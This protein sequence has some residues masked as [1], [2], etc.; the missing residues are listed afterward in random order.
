MMLTVMLIAW[1]IE[2]CP[3]PYDSLPK[4]QR[5]RL[6]RETDRVL[7]NDPDLSEEDARSKAASL[8]PHLGWIC[9][10]AAVRGSPSAEGEPKRWVAS[11]LDEEPELLEEFWADI[12]QIR[13]HG[14]KRHGSIRWV[15]FNGKRFDVPFL[16]ARTAVAGLEPT[17][18]KLTKTH[19]FRHSPHADLMGLW[20]NANYS[21]KGLCSFLGVEVEESPVDGSMVAGLVEEGRLEEVAT[22]CEND[23]VQTLRCGQA[24]T[25]LL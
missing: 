14:T 10:I 7:S 17:S 2:T 5:E 18:T 21:L 4:P 16:T 12:R 25:P 19:P 13:R 15:T 8:H 1:D 9:C 23:A 24:L 11:S 3:R 6:E 22:Y 20:P